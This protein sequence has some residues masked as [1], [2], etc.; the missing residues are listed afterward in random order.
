MLRFLLFPAVLAVVA[1]ATLDGADLSDI[2]KFGFVLLIALCTAVVYAW[3]AMAGPTVPGEISR[4]R[5]QGQEHKAHGDHAC[6]TDEIDGVKGNP[7]GCSPRDIADYSLQS[8]VPLK[9]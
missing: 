6:K 3:A 1:Y 7:H 4:Q 9:V 8:K 2:I 5:S